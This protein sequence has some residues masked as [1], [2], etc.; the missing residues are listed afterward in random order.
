MQFLTGEGDGF[1]DPDSLDMKRDNEIAI[2]TDRAID[3]LSREQA[4]AIR[5]ARGIVKLWQFPNTDYAKTLEKA[6]S[7]LEFKL[8]NHI[9]TWSL[10]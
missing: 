6:L 1:G 3:C 7:I 2:A 9:A 4:W 5:K 10:F 8:S